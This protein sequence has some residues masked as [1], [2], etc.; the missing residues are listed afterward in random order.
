MTPEDI[1]KAKRWNDHRK[2]L[3]FHAEIAVEEVMDLLLSGET[4]KAKILAG[5]WRRIKEEL[6]EWLS[7]GS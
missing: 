1:R 2:L 3:Q 5:E 6:G 4:T 7:E